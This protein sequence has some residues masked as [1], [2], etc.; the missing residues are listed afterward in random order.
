MV[1]ESPW[2]LFGALGRLYFT[3]GIS[4]IFYIYIYNTYV[5][6]FL[7]VFYYWP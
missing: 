1:E 6:L 5:G 3:S 2:P 4:S 7:L